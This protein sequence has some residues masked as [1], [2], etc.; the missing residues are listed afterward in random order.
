MIT[1][2]LVNTW[3]YI[4]FPGAGMVYFYVDLIQ[5]SS[6][7]LAERLGA[8]DLAVIPWDWQ[9]SWPSTINVSNCK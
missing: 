3:Y 1:L 9:T 4:D 7:G 6:E 5:A 2:V 8:A